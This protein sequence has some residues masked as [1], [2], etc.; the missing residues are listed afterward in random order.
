MSYQRRPSVAPASRR[1]TRR[2][3]WAEERLRGE[4]RRLSEKRLRDL[5]ACESQTRKLSRSRLHRCFPNQT[6]SSSRLQS[7]LSTILRPASRIGGKTE[8]K[9]KLA[10]RIFASETRR[11]I[12][13]RVP[14]F[15]GRE[16]HPNTIPSYVHRVYT[17]H[18]LG[19]VYSQRD[20]NFGKRVYRSARSRT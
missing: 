1:I 18:T 2:T 17:R 6:F 7:R 19:V 11:N 20:F 16:Q 12:S 8:W 10:E 14:W 9:R 3:A 15:V 13:T 5:L 4:T